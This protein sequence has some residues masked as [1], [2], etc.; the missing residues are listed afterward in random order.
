[1]T[2]GKGVFEVKGKTIA[3]IAAAA[4][5][6][7]PLTWPQPP[8]AGGPEQARL[9]ARFEATGLKPGVPFPEVSIYDEEGKPFHTRS[10]KGKY[11]VIVNGCLT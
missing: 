11:T 10:L 2:I 4:L 1:V 7:A 9:E 3:A 6:L 5:G 8:R